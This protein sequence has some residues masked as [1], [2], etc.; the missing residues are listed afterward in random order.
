[1]K[2]ANIY[3]TIASAVQSTA[4]Y[5]Y[6][7]C[8]AVGSIG[9]MAADRLLSHPE[10]SP[11]CHTLEACMLL[12]G[13]AYSQKSLMDTV[14]SGATNDQ[15][16]LDQFHLRVACF[17]AAGMLVILQNPIDGYM[18]ELSSQRNHP[19]ATAGPAVQTS[20]IPAFYGP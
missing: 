5:S 10:D 9:A 8:F 2:L 7:K 16:A 11:T 12:M 18:D 13:V 4:V 14:K 20:S 3:A 6:L 1:M 15:K 17:A 19:P